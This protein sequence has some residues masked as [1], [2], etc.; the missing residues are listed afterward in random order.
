MIRSN[1]PDDRGY[2]KLKN[3]VETKMN[4]GIARLKNS[5]FSVTFFSSTALIGML[6]ELGY[7]A[8]LQSQPHSIHHQS[9]D[10]IHI[11]SSNS[12]LSDSVITSRIP[13]VKDL[14]TL[15][16]PLLSQSEAS[17]AEE[18]EII[19]EEKRQKPT[20]TPVYQIEADEIRRESADSLSELLRGLPGFAIND[21]GFGADIHTGTLLVLNKFV[22]CKGSEFGYEKHHKL[23]GSTEEGLLNDRA[24]ET[25]HRWR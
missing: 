6:A 23:V 14:E 16:T 8:E 25:R 13:S 12:L 7:G 22:F 19:G 15:P 21:T 3:F 20:S 5:F 10:S 2:Q 9:S 17:E 1:S 18:E 4:S 24:K 11:D